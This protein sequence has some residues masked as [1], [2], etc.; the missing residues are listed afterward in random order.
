METGAFAL[1]PVRAEEAVRR[2]LLARHSDVVDRAVLDVQTDAETGSVTV[3]LRSTT[4]LVFAPAVPGAPDEVIVVA[5]AT[6][7]VLVGD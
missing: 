4:A 2:A 5:Q 6:A 1:D 3:T 7:D